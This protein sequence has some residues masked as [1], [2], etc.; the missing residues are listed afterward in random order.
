MLV[1][2]FVSALLIVTVIA[3]SA[4]A[5]DV[6]AAKRDLRGAE[7]NLEEHQRRY[8]Q[9]RM[10]VER[11]QKNL[12]GVDAA[13]RAPI[14]AQ[15]ADILRRAR[16]M[17]LEEWRRTATSEIERIFRFAE[18]KLEGWSMN[19]TRV[20]DFVVGEVD[21]R[22]PEALG[23]DNAKASLTDG[24]RTRFQ[25]MRTELLE[26]CKR[27]KIEV[28]FHCASERIDRIETSDADDSSRPG[29][30]AYVDENLSAQNV[31][32]DDPRVRQLKTR[33]EEV[34]AK[35]GQASQ[36]AAQK[37]KIER[38][39]EEWESKKREFAR[40]CPAWEHE[41][42]NEYARWK[43]TSSLNVDKALRRHAT[44]EEM[45]NEEVYKEAK[46]WFA[47]DPAVVALTAE[48][49][50]WR[51]EAATKV[52]AAANTLLDE[53]AKHEGDEGL[54][55]ALQTLL[56]Q[57]E[58][59]TVGAP[60]AAATIARARAAVVSAGGT[61]TSSGPTATSSGDGESVEVADAPDA[62]GGGGGF[63]KVLLGLMCCF[64]FLAVG[65]GVGFVAYKQMS[66]AKPA[67]PPGG[68]P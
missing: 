15:I 49:T 61:P 48:V 63:L 5:G 23:R 59:R 17:E 60:Q 21:N 20:V 2:K 57:L 16:I 36:A 58:E 65:G 55:L 24:D 66:A 31:P 64:G 12:E 67:A 8:E 54:A 1:R 22:L 50:T 53:V 25:A 6:E 41:I 26:T 45:M 29:H 3:G 44:A 33:L 68:T 18:Q 10:Y 40:D 9:A 27:K 28:H 34:L 39:Q 7:M 62:E 4:W 11:A 42:V 37:E 51:D 13:A 43:Q 52:C 30:I 19:D 47:A 46:Q 32:Q 35:Q 38:A 56:T 14:D